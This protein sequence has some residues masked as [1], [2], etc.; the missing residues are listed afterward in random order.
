MAEATYFDDKEIGREFT[1]ELENG[2]VPESLSQS[3]LTFIRQ[4]GGKKIVVKIKE[5]RKPRS[6]KQNKYMFGIIG[7]YL[8]PV[9]RENG[10]DWDVFDIHESIMAELG[11][12]TVIF[13]PKGKP[14]R[15]RMHSSDFNTLD[16]EEYL[17][18]FRAY[19]SSNLGVFIPLPN[20]QE[21]ELYNLKGYT[22]V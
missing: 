8:L 13:D 15:K 5:W 2:Q 11:Y 1:C 22:N 19:C 4:Y 7:K 16:M 14:H 12:T 9:Y 21:I 10:N 18:R 3:I 17:S 20:E 6:A